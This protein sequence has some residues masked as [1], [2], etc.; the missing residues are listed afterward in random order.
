MT[1]NAPDPAQPAAPSSSARPPVSRTVPFGVLALL[2]PVGVVLSVLAAALVRGPGPLV[3]T[4][5]ALVAALPGAFFGIEAA[6]RARKELRRP[7]ATRP[8]L[9]GLGLGLGAAGAAVS[10]LLGILVLLFVRSFS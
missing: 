2:P 4:G 5:W 9:A 10:A 6:T 3:V 7:V 1:S 8:R